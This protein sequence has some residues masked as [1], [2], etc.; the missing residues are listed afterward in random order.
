M[1]QRQRIEIEQQSDAAVT[2]DHEGRVKFAF[3]SI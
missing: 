3:V 2:E 1:L